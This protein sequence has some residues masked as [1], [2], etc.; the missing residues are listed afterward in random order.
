MNFDYDIVYHF[1][2][3]LLAL[4]CWYCIEW[5]RFVHSRKN[6]EGVF[7]WWVSPSELDQRWCSDCPMIGKE[8]PSRLDELRSPDDTIAGENIHDPS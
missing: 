5:L 1:F 3:M 7:N 4:R 2:M 6:K 8:N